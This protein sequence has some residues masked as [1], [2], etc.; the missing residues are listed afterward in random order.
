M[1][2]RLGVRLETKLEISLIP[3]LSSWPLLSGESQGTRL[4][5]L[6]GGYYAVVECTH[7]HIWMILLFQCLLGHPPGS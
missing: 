6:E 7:T 1:G 5:I 4:V 3:R 2:M